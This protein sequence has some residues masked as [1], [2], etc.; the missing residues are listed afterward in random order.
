M[1]CIKI[2]LAG[3]EDLEE[4]YSIEVASFDDPWHKLTFAHEIESPRTLVLAAELFEDGEAELVGFAASML[5]YEEAHI[6]SLAVAP[7]WRRI[8][9]GEKLMK[10]MLSQLSESG[11]N[12]VTLEVRESNQ[13]AINLYK[14]L[15]FVETGK[16]KN[17]Y[18]NNLEDAIIMWK[19]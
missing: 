7:N 5:M 10:K 13:A 1:D 11:Y 3:L 17:Y 16:R 15:G 9:L 19:R 2:R 4:L 6:T 12:A 18:M 8:G 14:K